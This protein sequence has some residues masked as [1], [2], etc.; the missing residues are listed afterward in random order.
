MSMKT[1]NGRGF[2]LAAF[3]TLAALA[4]AGPLLALAAGNQVVGSQGAVLRVVS[5]S[6]A[7]LFPGSTQFPA[8][9]QVLAL[10]VTRAGASQRLL[11]PGTEEVFE[12]YSP[13]LVHDSR[14]EITWLL[15]EGIHNGIHPLLYLRS[16]DAAAG[17]SEQ[18][19]L[20]GSPFSRKGHPQLV[21]TRDRSLET[22]EG[23]V[24][25]EVERAILHVFWWEEEGAELRKRYAPLVLE[26]G[27]FIG[28][29]PVRDVS[30]LFA[31]DLSVPPAG[32]G[33]VLKVQP[34]PNA[35]S[36][37]AG[38]VA[39]DSGRVVA[40]EVE[41]VPRPLSRLAEDIVDFVEA[42][43]PALPL[44]QLAALVRDRIAT[45]AGIHPATLDYVKQSVAGLIATMDPG[46]ASSGGMQVIGQKAG[47]HI[48]IIGQ[49]TTMEAPAPDE[50]MTVARFGNVKPWHHLRLSRV[51][52]RPLPAEVGAGAQLFLSRSGQEACLAWPGENKVI[53]RESAGEGWSEPQELGLGE[54]LDLNTAM[55][56]LAQRTTDR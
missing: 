20:S 32:F 3:F 9:H 44:E 46:E 17:W 48:L 5:G 4:T 8:E 42:Q 12:E 28:A 1:K 19:E 14:A 52:S 54:S 16:W 50:V 56:I 26:G 36:V 33:D 55:A 38:F 53:Y 31:A 22:G 2:V 13:T 25:L 18:I 41:V 21:V 40:L 29:H 51:A 39:Q 37:L 11:V 10:D 30:D 24:A 35:G 45:A 27:R 23:G 15:W 43:D 49:R 47:M 6:F 34:G 7:E